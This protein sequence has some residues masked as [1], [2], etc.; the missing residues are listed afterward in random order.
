MSVSEGKDAVGRLDCQGYKKKGIYWGALRY[1]TALFLVT[2]ESLMSPISTKEA[3][4]PSARNIYRTRPSHLPVALNG[5]DEI[6]GLPLPRRLIH[7]L[8]HQFQRFH[9]LGIAL[10]H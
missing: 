5:L 3:I 2:Q 9:P 4:L 10:H 1:I 8:Q 7:S 6:S